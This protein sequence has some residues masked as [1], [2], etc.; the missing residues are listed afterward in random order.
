ME[1]E[2]KLANS[3]KADELKEAVAAF[4][5][6]NGNLGAA[7]DRLGIHRH[8]MRARIGEAEGLLSTDLS[9]PLTR[10]ELTLVFATR[11]REFNPP[12]Q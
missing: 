10:A 11:M 3:A 6:E 7:A 5:F 12:F 1:V 9:H 8:T 4:L 2:E